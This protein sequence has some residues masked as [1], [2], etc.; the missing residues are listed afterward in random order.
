MRRIPL[1]GLVLLP[2]LV[3]SPAMAQDAPAGGTI[4]WAETLPVAMAAAKESKKPVMVCINAK[5]VD[6]RDVEEPAAKGLREVVYRDAR[7]VK[8]SADF[9]CVLLTPQGGV[10]EYDVL[11]ALGIEGTLVSPQHI[12]ISSE[13]DRILL[14]KPYWSHGSGDPAVKALLQM[15]DDAMAVASGKA[16]TKPGEGPAA[17]ASGPE[18]EAWIAERLAK[19]AGGGELRDQAAGDLA[20]EDRDGDCLNPLLALLKERKDD[21][22]LAV[23]V[24]RALGRDGLERAALPVADMLSHKDETVR[25]NAAVSL[26]YIG[27]HDEKVLA[28]LMKHLAKEKDE[29]IL[30]H[31]WRALGRCGV[32]NNNARAALLKEAS[33]A[34][35][36]FASY[37]PCIGLAYWKGDKKA[38]RGVE[39]MLK[40][41][42]VPG[43][44]RGGGQDVVK[45]GLVSWTLACI[46]DPESDRFVKDELI[47]GLKNVK[48]YWVEMLKTFWFNVAEACNGQEGAL[49]RVEGGVRTIVTYAKSFNEERYTTNLLDAYRKGREST[50]FK[51]LGE[52]LLDD[53]DGK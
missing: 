13:G 22:K 28:A 4:A 45:R 10:S 31:S 35:S 6:G 15:M 29:A 8:R 9:V 40:Q 19:V 26:E 12:F 33:A 24:V 49:E 47:D 27:S 18:R 44:R 50:G 2:A 23:A 17:P 41:I 20:R 1:L 32:G 48:D 39:K 21:V 25:G 11:R 51:P 5:F 14:R 30:N 46:G 36:E 37:G 42:G 34:K 43:G 38:A 52:H 53:G 3:W 7:I 16:P